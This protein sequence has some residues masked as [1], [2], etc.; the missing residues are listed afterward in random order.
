MYVCL[1]CADGENCKILG[2]VMCASLLAVSVVEFRPL[3][4]LVVEI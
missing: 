3:Y 1:K 2:F 4:I